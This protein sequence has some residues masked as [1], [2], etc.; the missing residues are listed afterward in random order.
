M[1]K[2]KMMR[3]ASAMMVLTLMSTSV[4]SG[5][6]AKY[7][8]SD[9]A[10]DS[11]R[12]AKW[13]VDFTVESELFDKTYPFVDSTT[14]FTASISVESDN[15]DNV[16]AP[17]T[18]GSGYSFQTTGTPEVSYKVTFD[19]DEGT[20]KNIYLTKDGNTYYPVKFTV[21]NGSGVTVL[22]A[23]NS[24]ADIISAVENCQ[25][26]YDVDTDKYYTTTDGGT[27]WVEYGA[28]APKFEVV[29]A[30]E[31]EVDE[32]TDILDTNLGD[33]AAGK[34]VTDVGATA[35]ETNIYLKVTATATQID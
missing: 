1:K 27:N 19:V 8:T 17:G 25:Y 24:I 7:V 15:T 28:T 13:G 6:F 26:L 10:T 5:T 16:V 9:S 22:P 29:W 12:V 4:I 33:I 11:A 18:E 35:A 30:W 31:F 23:T 20:A 3:L 2:N 32:A 21:Y 14:G 34:T